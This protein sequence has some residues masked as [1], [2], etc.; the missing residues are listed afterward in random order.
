MK[1]LIQCLNISGWS[2]KYPFTSLGGK[3]C[4]KEQCGP[5]CSSK[6][7]FTVCPVVLSLRFPNSWPVA[8]IKTTSVKLLCIGLTGF[9]FPGSLIKYKV[10]RNQVFKNK[11]PCG[12]LRESTVLCITPNGELGSLHIMGP[13]SEL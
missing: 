10:I 4:G 12:G 7:H 8:P 11:F 9:A 2:P 13:N 1:K 3:T 6:P 5:V